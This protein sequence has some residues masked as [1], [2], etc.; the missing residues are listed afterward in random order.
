M[1]KILGDHTA[2][3]VAMVVSADAQNRFVRTNIKF[4]GNF[5]TTAQFAQLGLQLLG[6]LLCIVKIIQIQRNAVSHS[7]Q[8]FSVHDVA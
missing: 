3:D 6:R 4:G 1:H 7:T 5:R 2:F 8:C